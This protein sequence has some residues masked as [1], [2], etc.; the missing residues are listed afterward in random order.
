[1]GRSTNSDCLDGVLRAAAPVELS[2]PEGW[3]DILV[4]YEAPKLQ[5]FIDGVLVDEEFTCG[6]I[7]HFR[8]P[9]RCTG[10]R[11]VDNIYVASSTDCV[12]FEKHAEPWVRIDYTKGGDV[13]PLVWSS[14]D[15]KRFYMYVARRKHNNWL[16]V[17][18]DL[19]IWKP[20]EIPALRDVIGI[21]ATHHEWNG[22]YYWHDNNGYRMS[23]LPAEHPEALFRELVQHADG[24]LGLMWPEE[25]IPYS[26]KPIPLAPRFPDATATGDELPWAWSPIPGRKPLGFAAVVRKTEA[27][28]G[29]SCSTDCQAHDRQD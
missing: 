22:W 6:E 11:L 12:R 16:F 8:S 25:M 10:H 27:Q 23:R 5:L 19:R 2:G 21:C 26:G 13:N 1:M 3:H 18:G 14:A 4:C 20:A 7:C 24:T 17:S 9:C 15:G 28:G 29:S